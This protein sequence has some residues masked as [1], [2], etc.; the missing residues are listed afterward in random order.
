MPPMPRTVQA[1]GTATSL[2]SRQQSRRDTTAGSACGGLRL[3]ATRMNNADPQT[4]SCRRGGPVEEG[5]DR[6][7]DVAGAFF[8]VG[9]IDGGLEFGAD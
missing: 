6:V 5:A 2:H 1:K 8:G 7:F 4:C 3:G 9:D